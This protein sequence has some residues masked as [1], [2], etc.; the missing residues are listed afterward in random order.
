MSIEIKELTVTEQIAADAVARHKA[1]YDP[2]V[3]PE[4][5]K[6]SGDYENLY[7]AQK[8]ET[9]RLKNVL[10]ASR[11]STA[12]ATGNRQATKPAVTAD[13]VRALVGPVG[14][15]KMTRSEKLQSLGLEPASVD[16][17]YLRR[18]FGRSN[19]GTAAS[20]LMKQNPS[21]YLILREAAKILNI[22][23]N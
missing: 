8:E 12:P 14:V 16:D 6:P 7:L 5:V 1:K 22:F 15:L 17:G 4:P 23:C 18:L 3:E 21:R 9:E 2:P 11:L 10:A 19:D 13:R 20:E